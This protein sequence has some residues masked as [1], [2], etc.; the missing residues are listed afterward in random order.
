MD[1]E[2]LPSGRFENNAL[3]LLLG[4]LANNLLRMRYKIT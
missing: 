3:V 2:R 1:L 4:M